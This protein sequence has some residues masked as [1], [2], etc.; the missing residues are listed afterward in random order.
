MRLLVTGATGYIG[1]RLVPRL[2]EAGHSVCCLVR[3][4]H[5]LE[6][7]PWTDGVKLVQGDVLDSSSV[8]LAMRGMEAA[9]YLVHSMRDTK[10]FR[11]RDLHAARTFGAVALEAGVGRIIYVGGL[12]DPDA[13]LSE[14][15][16]SRQ[17]TGEILRLSGVPVIEF[18][19]GVVVGSGSVSFEMIRFLTE[20]VPVMICPKW[21]RTRIQ[22]IG[23]H[24]LLNY[25]AEALK[26]EATNEIVEVGG[27]DVVTYGEMMRGY[28]RQRGLRRWMIAVPLLTPSLSSYWV[29]W[30]TPIP[31]A[32]AEPLIEGLRNEVVVRTDWA[33]TLFP[34]LHPM[35][36]RE[37][38]DRALDQMFNGVLET[39]WS[40]SVSSAS[41]EQSVT[42]LTA[43]GG[44]LVERREVPVSA[45]AEQVFQTF[46][47]AGGDEGWFYMNW[48]WRLRG[49]MDLMLGGVGLRRGR[50]DPGRVR[51]G[52]ALDFWRVEEVEEDRLL[53]LRAEMKVPG[54]AWLTF[55]ARPRDDGGADLILT[56]AFQPH[57]LTGLLYWRLLYP[58][59]ALIFSGMIRKIARRAEST[60]SR[61]PQAEKCV[62]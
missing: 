28:A 42:T 15:L 40:D 38:V 33:R 29:H 48:A 61:V 50:R 62:V 59:H 26:I 1:G 7:R 24:D 39:R 35:S 37:A 58:F 52:D 23:I 54:Q 44:Y 20:R 31:A 2:L 9:Y 56:A 8:R 22:P 18:R 41:G 4:P 19:A 47:R 3:D 51:V 21:V 10:G 36:Y 11:D 6:G 5:R 43:S 32:I 13:H 55:E 16:R 25:L 57:G 12:G 17:E 14:H 49:A 30:V 60:R 34:N 45:S 46:A 27:A 53:R